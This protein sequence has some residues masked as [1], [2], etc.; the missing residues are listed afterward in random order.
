M[1]AETG[2]SGTLAFS[3]AS[4]VPYTSSTYPLLFSKGRCG[5]ASSGMANATG[6]TLVETVND[7]TEVGQEQQ[8]FS[9]RKCR[10]GLGSRFWAQVLDESRSWVQVGGGPRQSTP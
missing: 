2:A 1:Q 5:L 10:A 3:H 6:A 4:K 8:R 9:G 7:S